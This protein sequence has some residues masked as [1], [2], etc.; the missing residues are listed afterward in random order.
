LVFILAGITAQSSVVAENPPAQEIA[1]ARVDKLFAEWDKWDSPGASLAVFK[2]DSIVYKRGYGSAQLEYNI[3]ITASTIF[4]VASVSKQFTAFAVALLASQGK[5]SWDDEVRK[6]IPEMPDFGKTITLRHLVHHMSGLRDQW[7]ALGIAGWRL[8]D[9]ITKE[10]I[11]KMVK[12]QKELNFNPGE[13]YVYCNTGFTLLAEVVARITGQSFPKWTEENIFKPLGMSNTHFHDDH[14]MIVKNMAYSYEPKE[15]GGF[16]KSVLSYANVGATSLFTTV[17]DLTRWIQNFFDARVGGPGVIQQ[18][19]EQG[20]LNNGKKIDYAFGL[21]IA[22]YRGLNTVGHSGGDAGYR[23]HVVWFP[24]QKFGVAVL[25]NLGTMNPGGLALK[26]ADIYLADKLAPEKPKTPEFPPK[27]PKINP[28]VYD[29]YAGKYQLKDGP[30]ITITREKDQLMGEVSGMPKFELIPESETIF[31]LKI[32]DAKIA[33]ERDKTGKVTQFILKQ[34]NEESP[35]KRLEPPVLKPEELEEYAGE[36]YSEELG[37]TYTLAVQEGKLI[38][39]H[40]RNEDSI[41]MPTEPDTFAGDHWYFGKVKFERD[42]NKKVFG[43]LLSGSRVR[44]LRFDKK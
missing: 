1:E 9:V 4:H 6:H 37:T 12:H 39:Q 15:G 22:P 31:S 27:V 30:I 16:K 3:P 8:D 23:S 24:D 2:D 20:V 33:F 26:V 13:E 34:E 29:A 18:M 11:L 40:R 41:L 35:A 19:Q 17:E 7:E 36:Y 32:L 38:A 10:Q 43:F 25:S 28:A 44:N 42:N 5:L 21:V 14:E